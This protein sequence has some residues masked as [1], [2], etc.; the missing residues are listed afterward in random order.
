MYSRCFFSNLI[1]LL[2]SHTNMASISKK[3]LVLNYCHDHSEEKIFEVR[4]KKRSRLWS[5]K[6][7]ACWIRSIR[8][9]NFIMNSKEC[10]DC[11]HQST[12]VRNLL[13]MLHDEILQHSF[14]KLI[15][16]Q[17]RAFT[18]M[19]SHLANNINGIPW[20]S[21]KTIKNPWSFWT[22]SPNKPL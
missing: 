9:E 7:L 1:M 18:N 6:S 14:K 17:A 10:R 12:H 19:L 22:R 3:A 11:D 2:Y 5:T 15:G 16:C 4:C 13:N 8:T 20:R 21:Y